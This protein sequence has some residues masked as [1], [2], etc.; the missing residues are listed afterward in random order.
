MREAGNDAKSNEVG[1]DRGDNRN[2]RCRTLGGKNSRSVGHDDIELESNQLGRQSGES[3]LMSIGKAKFDVE[4]PAIDVAEVTKAIRKCVDG[5]DKLGG[6]RRTQ[7]SDPGN[8]LRLLRTRRERPCCCAAER[9]YEFAPCH[10]VCH[11]HSRARVPQC[12]DTMVPA[13]D[14]HVRKGD[15]L[16]P[17]SP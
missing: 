17:P 1:S 5:S 2:G 8:P 6:R 14:L 10:G 9:S 3:L 13:C 11:P 12:K 15:K 4:V 16:P 7:V